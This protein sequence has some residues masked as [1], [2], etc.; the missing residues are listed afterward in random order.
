V[1]TI[2][3]IDNERD[4]VMRLG[5]LLEAAF[6]E[7]TVLPDK[8]R[9]EQEPLH[10]WTAVVGYLLA[11]ADTDVVL[12]LDLSLGD[13]DWDDVSRGLRRAYMF[14][15]N[16]P[17]WTFVAYTK[18]SLFAQGE[19]E[20]A[21]T[22]DGLLEKSELARMPSHE[23]AVEFVRSV[24]ERAR[25][26][27]R[28]PGTETIPKDSRIVDSLG[29]R[30]FRAAFSDDTLGDLVRT[31]ARGWGP[32]QV[33]SL[34]SGYSGAFM[35]ALTAI[36][37][38]RSLILKVARS[39]AT[40]AHELR[41]QKDH[42]AELAPFGARFVPIEPELHRLRDGSGVYYRQMPVQGPT[43]LRYCLTHDEADNVA[44][45]GRVVRLCIRV[46]NAVPVEGRPNEVARTRFELSP[47]DIG[48]LET[49]AEFLAELGDALVVG[50]L[51]PSGFPAPASIAREVTELA[52]GWAEDELTDVRLAEAVQ[53]GDLNPGNVMLE[54]DGEPV[55]IDCQRLQRWP[56]GYDV[57]RLSG[58]LRIRLTDVR[59]RSDW[60]PFKFASWCQEFG[61]DINDGSELGS[62][63]PEAA[64]CESE[65]LRY[66][67]GLKPEA[68]A[69]VRYGYRL[70]SLWDM[71]KITSYQD[72]S[73]MKRALALIRC[74]VLA[75]RLRKDRVLLHAA[76]GTA[77]T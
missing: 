6:P 22:F 64:F 10:E 54:A 60:L 5:N 1:P 39:E 28:A 65:F 37:P 59:D 24:I 32:L 76:S 23:L 46:L 25:R 53:H 73:P 57:A 58:L 45:L 16:R 47:I 67:A 27:R 74:W 26:S 44:V 55:L 49:S 20:F 3:V 52:R 75:R 30:S 35:L 21:L 34:T 11:V 29:M 51:W 36:P 14:R 71:I 56:L 40:V 41:A 8:G 70:G 17:N 48:R 77:T 33:E 7:W 18:N 68:A 2:V 12:C 63:C 38:E 13:F 42:L 15:S 43:L 4:E 69:S 66:L 61:T 50:R 19:P 31:E 62:T 9:R 72:I